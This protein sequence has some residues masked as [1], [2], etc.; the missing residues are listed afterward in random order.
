M[1]TRGRGH[2]TFRP[3]TPDRQELPI[4]NRRI[5]PI[6]GCGGGAIAPQAKPA[7]LVF[8]GVGA[9]GKGMTAAIAD[10]GTP[11]AKIEAV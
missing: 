10:I 8:L 4:A 11:V 2:F 1:I 5:L 3:G 7:L 6:A 9:R